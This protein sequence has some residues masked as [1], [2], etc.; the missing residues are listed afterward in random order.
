MY[1]YILYTFLQSHPE[2]IW[3]SRI[4]QHCKLLEETM[5]LGKN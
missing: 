5:K 2:Y 3:L 1:N 4:E